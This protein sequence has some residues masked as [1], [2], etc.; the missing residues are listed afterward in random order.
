MS[1]NGQALEQAPPGIEPRLTDDDAGRAG[2]GLMAKRG[3]VDD[4]RAMRY[5]FRIPCRRTSDLW[6]ASC[7]VYGQGNVRF[8]HFGACCAPMGSVDSLFC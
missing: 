2:E 1:V 8:L 6:L 4:G 7:T 3:V 5:T